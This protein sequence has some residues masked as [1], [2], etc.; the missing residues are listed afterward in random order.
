MMV[1]EG[2]VRERE[3]RR[4]GKERGKGGARKKMRLKEGRGKKRV[5]IENEGERERERERHGGWNRLSPVGHDRWE[6][7]CLRSSYTY[8]PLRF[9]SRRKA[10]STRL[11]GRLVGTLVGRLMRSA[12]RL[13]STRLEG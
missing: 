3:R 4:V 10:G 8:I 2:A 5:R 12:K 13:F 11:L 1:C 6:R 7:C 9:S